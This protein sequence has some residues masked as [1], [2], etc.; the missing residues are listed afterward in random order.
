MLNKLRNY[1][2]PHWL[3]FNEQLQANQRLRWMMWCIIYIFIFYFSLVLN[4]WRQE[5][6]QTV[7]QLQRTSFK[8]DQLK[9][10]T[11][12]P[13]RWEK[14]KVAGEALRGK[15]WET[16][17]E[18]LAE[19]DLQN[20]LRKL[21]TDHN[22]QNYRPRLAPTEKVEI[23]GRSL[24]KVA[25]EVTG[26]VA[27]NQIDH[28]MKALADNPKTLEIERFSYSPQRSGQLNMQVSAYF[29]V[30]EAPAAAPAEGDE[31]ATR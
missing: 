28:F 19:A 16:Q 5:H 30:V 10:Q 31:N 22:A 18:S 29:L 13:E 7:T 4:D 17:S 1:L 26:A 25:A 6:N 2:T 12:W 11:Q 8:L 20:Y 24:I 15:L 9:H 27:V 3:K 14:E 21:M 23:G